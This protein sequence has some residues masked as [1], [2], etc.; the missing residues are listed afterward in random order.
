MIRSAV[1]LQF[2][3][4]QLTN[5]FSILQGSDRLSRKLGKILREVEFVLLTLLHIK[6]GC[7][8]ANFEPIPPPQSI[9]FLKLGVCSI[10]WQWPS[11]R[12][13]RIQTS[14]AFILIGIPLHSLLDGINHV[15]D[16]NIPVVI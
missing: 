8:V 10:P 11:Q 14:A 1:V 4:H 12:A 3:T 5:N 7:A 16:S 6:T 15:S 2:F 13:G 9:A